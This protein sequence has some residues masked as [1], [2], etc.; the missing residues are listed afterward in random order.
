MKTKFIDAPIK[1]DGVPL[2]SHWAY[3]MFDLRGDSMV[4]FVGPCEV[5]RHQLVDL[6]DA[7]ANAPIYSACMLSFIAEHFDMDLEKAILRQRL[8]ACLAQEE[9][10]KR[11]KKPAL[12]REGNDL[13][14]GKAKVTVSIATLSP[15]SAKIHLGINVISK[16][17]PVKTRGLADYKIPARALARDILLRYAAEYEDMKMDRCKVRAVP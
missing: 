11:L 15:V 2:Q 7:K 14:D 9:I 1:Y 13:Y 17:T 12:A 16:G 8:L 6:A 3:K 4:A 5:K 10:N